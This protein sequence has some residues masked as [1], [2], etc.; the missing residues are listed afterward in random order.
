MIGH[1]MR[2]Y[3]SKFIFILVS[4]I[5]TNYFEGVLTLFLLACPYG[6]I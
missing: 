3:M 2:L 5:E 4:S 1:I 6:I